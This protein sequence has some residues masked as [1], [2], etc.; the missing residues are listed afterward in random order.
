[1]TNAFKLRS[2]EY[3]AAPVVG[4]IF[5]TKDPVAPLAFD[6]VNIPANEPGRGGVVGLPVDG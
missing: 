2:H 3:T 5:I 6:A 4:E 1:M